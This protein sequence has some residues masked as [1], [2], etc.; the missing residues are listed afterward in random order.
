MTIEDKDLNEIINLLTSETGIIPRESHKV[1]IKRYL[2]ERIDVLLKKGRMAGEL[3]CIQ[4]FKSLLAKD[5]KELSLLINKASVNE[6]YFFREEKQFDILKNTVFPK[7]LKRNS[8]V[9]IWSAASSSGEEIYS[10]ALLAQACK[11][12]ADFTASDINTDVLEKL[13]KGVY[14]TNSIRTMDGAKYHYL[15]APYKKEDG[16]IAF[17]PELTGSIIKELINLSELASDNLPEKLPENQTIIFI[18]NVFIY[19]TQ[20]MRAKILSTL[21]KKCLA[22]GGYIFVSMSEI[23]SIDNGII[24]PELKRIMEGNV[25]YFQKEGGDADRE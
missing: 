5:K 25:F 12:R 3:N 15:L 10:L 16:T 17:S 22:P 8:T 23:A 14:G 13:S 9:K 20:E 2:E 24:P 4:I 18:R 11:I 6:T 19:F 1:S 7:L 21:A